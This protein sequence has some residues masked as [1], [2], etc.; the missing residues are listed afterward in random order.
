[1]TVQQRLK[2]ATR[3][4]FRQ[5]G[6]L[7]AVA[8]VIGVSHAQ[9]GRYQHVDAPDMI[10]VDKAALLESQDGVDPHITRTMAAVNGHVLVALPR[11]HAD[12]A[13]A[14]HLADTARKAGDVLSQLG[15]ALA[16]DGDVSAAEAARVLPDVEQAISVLSGVQAALV[17]RSAGDVS[18]KPAARRT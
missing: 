17:A 14:K 3:Q 11:V 16:N 2:G 12:G 10:S 18:S 5:F 8:A 4:L 1:M 13:W 15:E 6:S 7:E 9:A